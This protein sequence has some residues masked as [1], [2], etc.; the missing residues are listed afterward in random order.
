MNRPHPH[1]P[2]CGAFLGRND[3]W[4][5]TCPACGATH[6]LNPTPVAVL[7][8]PVGSGI[9]TVR[10]S[11]PPRVGEL[12]LPGGFID[13]GETWQEAASRELH[14]ETG[15]TVAAETIELFDVHSAGNTL[16]VFAVA[17]GVDEDAL[18]HSKRRDE[19]SELVVVYEAREL[20]FPLHSQALARWIGREN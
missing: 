1:C 3:P 7:L 15:L 6:Y 9:L 2:A 5:R 10:R 17:P 11:I 19:V 13:A 20:A 14:E 8:Q 16:L 4:P 12:A 18:D